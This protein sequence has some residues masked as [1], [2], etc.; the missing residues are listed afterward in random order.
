MHHVEVKETNLM[1]VEQHRTLASSD[2]Y[3]SR[4]GHKTGRDA[5]VI[6]Y[7]KEHGKVG[8][9]TISAKMV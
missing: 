9:H 5:Q 4:L 6:T 8:G 7:H 1:V 2:A 3:S